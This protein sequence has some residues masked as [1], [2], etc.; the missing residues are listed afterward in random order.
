MKNTWLLDEIEKMLKERSD[1]SFSACNNLQE[2]AINL[3]LLAK[4]S[5]SPILVDMCLVLNI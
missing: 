5:L 2:E 4:K 1:F 3:A